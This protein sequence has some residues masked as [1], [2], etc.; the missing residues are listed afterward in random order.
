MKILSVLLALSFSLHAKAEVPG[1]FSGN[2]SIEHRYFG[3]EG[4]YL[5]KDRHQASFSLHPTYDLSWD[6]DRQVVSFEG[7]WRSDSLDEERSHIDVRELSYTASWANIE[8]TLGISKVFWGVTES[9]HLVDVINQTD[10]VEN[11]DGEEKLGQPMINTTFIT[12]LGN[13]ETFVLPYFRQRT[14]AG[15]DG[16]YRG[17]QTV[18]QHDAEYTHG[19]EEKRVDYALRWSG[20]RGDLDWGLS[21]FRG[22]DREPV[23]RLDDASR[24]L[25]PIYGQARQVGLEFQ[26]IYKDLIS[27]AELRYK[28]TDLTS[29]HFA[30]TLGIEYTFYG[31]GNRVDIGLLYEW[32]YDSR[33]S[34]APFGTGNASFIGSRVVMNDAASAEALIGAVFDNRTGRLSTFRLETSRRFGSNVKIDLE[35]NLFASPPEDSFLSHVSRDDTI[36]ST[37]KFYF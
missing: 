7:F 29:S 18:R 6:S 10:G 12:P 5:N 21:Y 4:A 25:I 27:K 2:F 17:P 9:Q 15:G 31:V 28:D 8:L 35:V 37:L 33:Q 16:R 3:S 22:T 20:Y 24:Q 32:L 23:L 14:F 11:P 13:V 1:E 34:G 30:T 19:D 36:Q 26:H